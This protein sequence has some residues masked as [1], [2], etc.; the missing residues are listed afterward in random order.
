MYGGVKANQK[1]KRG[2]FMDTELARKIFKKIV[3]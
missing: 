1:P 2:H 3:A